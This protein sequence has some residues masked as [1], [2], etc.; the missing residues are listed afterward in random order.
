M[1]AS[2]T[3]SSR[4]NE[5]PSTSTSRSRPPTKRYILFIIYLNFRF[6]S[7]NYVFRSRFGTSST[8]VN[9]SR[10][11]SIPTSGQGISTTA[12]ATLATVTTSSSV[13]QDVTSK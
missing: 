5:G 2:E 6:K 13:A 10:M 9:T 4:N 12:T 8:T 3:S 7:I 1:S 11:I